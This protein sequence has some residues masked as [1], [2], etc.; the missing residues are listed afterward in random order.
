[1]KNE[2]HLIVVTYQ[3]C[4]GL[5]VYILSHIYQNVIAEASYDQSECHYSIHKL[6]Q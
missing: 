6:V 2:K 4:V 3:I 1:M 5:L